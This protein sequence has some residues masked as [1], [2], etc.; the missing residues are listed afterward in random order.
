MP[1]DIGNR[2]I[3][4]VELASGANAESTRSA[5]WDDV[6][7]PPATVPELD[8]RDIDLSTDLA[9]HRLAA[10]LLIA[11]MTGGHPAMTEINA[12]LARAAQ[13]LGLAVGAGSQRAALRSPEAI[14]SFRV[15]R[16]EAPDAVLIANVGACQL[17]PQDT[18]PPLTVK[19]LRV[20]ISMLDAQLLAVHLNVVQ[21]LVQPEGDRRFRGILASIARVVEDAP[22]PVIAK[23][24][25]SGM[26]RAAALA[27]AETGVAAIDVGG[28]G[29]TTFARIEGGRIM[30]DDGG[31]TARLG[32]TFAGWGV[33]TA[34][35]VLAASSVGP[36][37]IA[38]G[39]VRSGLDAAKAIALGATAVGIGRPALL[40]A[41]A[42]DDTLQQELG[43]LLEELRAT[44]TLLGA[45]TISSLRAMRPILT[46]DVLAWTRQ[47]GLE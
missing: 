3:Q 39:G 20:L 33:P 16:E 46:G 4:H 26:T 24:T 17:V 42:G 41:R 23:E 37:V 7:L 34:V 11:S 13:R 22:V 18:E 9:G 25:G 40:G 31:R 15:L 6:H 1:G 32:A 45:S 43:L 14:P 10:P 28:A 12:T 35:S 21:E 47:Q 36:P 8:H 19:D 44:M 30:D 38:T 5:G 29:G 27:L 2:K